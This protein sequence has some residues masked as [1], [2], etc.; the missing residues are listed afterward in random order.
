VRTSRRFKAFVVALAALCVSAGLASAVS[1]DAQGNPNGPP[2]GLLDKLKKEARGSVAASI[3]DSTKYYGFVRVAHGGDL[4]PGNSGNPQAKAQAFLTEYGALLGVGDSAGSLVAAGTKTDAKGA[5]RV[6][7][8]QVYRGV[9]VLGGEIRAHVDDDGS[10]TAV[11]GNVIPDLELATTPNLSAA[12]AGQ[13][14]VAH[15]IADPPR[16]AN[17]DVSAF[18]TAADLT[19]SAGLLVYR[20]GLV[21]NV[22]GTSQLVYEVEVTNGK[23]VREFVYVHAHAGKIVNRYSAVAGVLHRRLFEGRPP[24]QVWN[25][26]DPFPGSLNQD[27]Q[28]IVT[29]SGHTY[30]LFFNAFGRDS[31]DGAGAEMQSINND[32]QISCPN[33]NWNGITTNYC[34]GVTGDDTVGHEWAHAYT[35]RTH[36]LIY[37]WQPGALNESYSDIWGEVVDLVNGVGTDDPDTVRTVGSCS[38]HAGSPAVVINSPAS[39]AR[40]CDAGRAFFGPAVDEVGV[41]GD[42]VL[43]N[44][45]VAVT[46]NGCE[47]PFVNAAAIAGNVALVDRGVCGFAVKVKN[48]Q[49]AGAIAV[50]VANTADAVQG[51]GGADPTITIPSLLI[52]LSNGNAIKGELALSSTVNVSLKEVPESG[53]EDSYR[54]LS[55]EDDPAFAGA[56][57]DM[58]TPTCFGDPGKVTD[59]EYHCDTSDNGGVHSNSGVPNHGFALLVDGGTYNG[60]TVN[61]I[62]L[63]KAAHLYWRAQSVYQTKTS[64][65]ADHADALEASCADLVG[66]TLTGLSTTSTPAPAPGVTFA[67]ADCASVTAMIAAVELREDPTEQ[68]NFT[69]LLDPD[70][71]DLCPEGDGKRVYHEDFNHPEGL[72]GWTVSNAGVFSGWPDLDW[73]QDSSL[74]GGRNGRAAFAEDPDAGNCDGGAGD[75]SGVMRLESPVIRLKATAITQGFRL[76]FDHYVATELGWDGGNL[77][78]SINGGP[79]QVV[80][81]SAFLFNP[82]NQNLNTAAAGNTNPLAGEPGFT[83]TDGGQVTGSWGQSHVDLSAFDVDD[84]DRIRLRFDFGMDGCTG[85]DGWYVDDVVISACEQRGPANS[86]TTMRKPAGPLES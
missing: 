2:P 32:P 3:E 35:E 53:A 77:K 76:S 67:A 38:T 43:V 34:S 58:W 54:W 7:Y 16:D 68:C 24:V 6:T 31:W 48:A 80:P 84:E 22:P 8:N 78:I 72:R 42:V 51:M 47:T 9:P 73:V 30:W 59:A 50:V 69:P 36:N 13:R 27:Q 41:T 82:Y 66:D 74:P 57:R 75:I 21:R 61:A 14:A 19:A 70:A 28:N 81:A 23:N 45:G 39:I 52:S 11:N 85:I 86:T 15:V 29:F 62:G 1:A 83:G 64:D 71:P 10:L 65:F 18:L 60:Q 55:G 17:G 12:Q 20:V 49:N 4:L 63:V 44:D 79:Y 33:A 40:V 25:E 56:I 26:G 46:S 5:T 37:Q